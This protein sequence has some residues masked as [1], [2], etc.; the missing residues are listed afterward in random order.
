MKGCFELIPSD[1]SKLHPSIL[2]LYLRLSYLGNS[3]ITEIDRPSSLPCSH[4]YAQEQHNCIEPYEFRELDP[5][6]VPSSK[7]APRQPVCTELECVCTESQKDAM[8]RK[9]SVATCTNEVCEIPT[10]S[11]DRKSKRCA[12]RG[13]ETEPLSVDECTGVEGMH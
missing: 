13:T 12:D 1:E 4:F 8:L 9:N 11:C 10:K 6:D 7:P 5:G 2:E 3:V